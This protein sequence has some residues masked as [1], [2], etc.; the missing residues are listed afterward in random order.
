[1]AKQL[2][3]AKELHAFSTEVTALG[4]VKRVRKMLD[5]LP[6]MVA[7]T[8]WVKK[9]NGVGRVSM[10]LKSVESLTTPQT[11]RTATTTRKA[12]RGMHK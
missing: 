3:S 7:F 11:T 1:M 9:W 12:A 6:K 8:K 5:S 2:Y 10:M 4:G